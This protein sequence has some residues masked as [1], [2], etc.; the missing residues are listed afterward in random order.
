[1]ARRRAA[2]MEA[3]IDRT[4]SLTGASPI[5]LS[6]SAIASATEMSGSG[7]TLAW[8]RADGSYGA[9]AACARTP[10][11][12]PGPYAP[13]GPVPGGPCALGPRAASAP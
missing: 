12:V 5:I 1:M 7:S 3:A 11:A 4:C 6:S 13:F 8:S 10:Y 9:A 2:S